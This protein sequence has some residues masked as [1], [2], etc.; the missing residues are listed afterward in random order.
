M[1]RGA[2]LLA[3]LGLAAAAF[4]PAAAAAPEMPARMIETPMLADDVAA[5]KL[6]PVEERI[7]EEPEVV[8]LSSPGLS[9]GVPGGDLRT[10]MGRSRDVR[11]MVV[12]GYARLVGYD[13][14]F[15]IEPD[16]LKSVDVEDGRIFT[17][18]LRKGHKWSDGQPFT[19][20][21]FR[22]WWEDFANDPVVSKGGPPVVMLVD[23][24][25]PKFE[26][27]DETTVRYT[28]AKPNPFFLP[29]LAGA[30]PLYI[31]KP[32]HYLKQFHKK[33]ADPLKL[34]AA[35]SEH[36]QRNWV[37]LLYEM[38]RQY[39]NENPDLPTLE[40]WVLTTR[41]PS[42]RYIFV[43]NPYYH[44]IDA[45]GHQL[46]YIDRWIMGI[47]NSSLIP[48]KVGAGD[49]D[50]QAQALAFNN[51]PFLKDAEKRNGFSVRLWRTARGSHVA[52]YPNLNATDPMWGPLVRNA[53]FRRALSLAIDRDDINQSIYFGMA[54]ETGNAL[55][56]ASPLYDRADASRWA[57]YDPDEANRILDS[58][59]LDARDEDG[60]RLLPDGTPMDL[61]VE[62]TGGG[63][64]QSDV[65][66]LVSEHFE[67]V[68]IRMH[69]RVLQRETF[70]NRVF[71]GATVMSVWSGLENGIPNADTPPTELA[72]TSQ[73]QYQWPRW[74]QYYET[75]GKAG[76]PIDLA[77]GEE[78][79]DLNAA[80]LR[81]ADRAKRREIWRTM[82][83]IYTNQ[84]FSIGIVAG[85]PQPVVVN[86]RLRNVPV[87]GIFNWNPG[88]H[89]GVYRPDTFWFA[90]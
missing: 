62:T 32:A 84:V 56:P 41:P 19:A 88:A 59:G 20:E 55:L 31:Y 70:R 40:P 74:G 25:K 29:A 37:A 76:T 27:L 38:G 71:S 61:I 39:R 46:P 47:A 6:P 1:R 36:S 16:I 42:D 68:G 89:F 75:G 24:K 15:E 10:L 5:G 35:V 33:Y 4:R 3:V 2:A 54:L 43:R 26:V 58:L 69:V 28:W 85:V 83:D 77:A 90:P 50:L 86:D 30:A 14:D 63:M 7:P 60:I 9:P 17:L 18:H 11:R 72:P 13:R 65:L 45:Q 51:M 80:W 73:M 87:E 23:G 81:T 64:E 78:L 52:L 12:Y 44:R 49:S 66:Q 53:E 8:D 22:F 48:A 57:R 82:L 67:E 34:L 79:S 21:D